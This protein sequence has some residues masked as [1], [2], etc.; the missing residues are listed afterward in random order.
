MFLIILCCFLGNE[1]ISKVYNDDPAKK[2]IF[3]MILTEKG[4]VKEL[5]VQMNASSVP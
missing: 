1:V 4:Q 5:K 3:K 2:L